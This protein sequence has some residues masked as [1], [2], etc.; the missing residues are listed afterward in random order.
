MPL[1]PVRSIYSATKA[2][3][4]SLTANVRMDLQADY[5]GVHIS[6]IMPGIVSTGFA[7]NARGATAGPIPVPQGSPMRPQT[8]EDVAA[9][10]ARLIEHPVAEAYTNP[11]SP[12]MARRYYEQLGAFTPLPQ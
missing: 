5:P 3:V 7:R 12:E 11:A 6:V 9:A 10:I 2:A 4:N 1:A 8:A